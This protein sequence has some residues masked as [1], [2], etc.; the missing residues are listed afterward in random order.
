MTSPQPRR[1]PGELTFDIDQELDACGSDVLPLPAGAY[2][3]STVVELD[4]PS[5]LLGFSSPAVEVRVD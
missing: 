2:W 1:S 3:V 4:A 5:E